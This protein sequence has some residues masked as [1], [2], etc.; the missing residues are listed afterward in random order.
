MQLSE[1]ITKDPSHVVGVSE[2]SAFSGSSLKYM[3]QI[4][5]SK[6]KQ[7]QQTQRDLIQLFCISWS[8]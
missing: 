2:L 6:T 1:V 4:Y 5:N 3:I 7:Q 8:M